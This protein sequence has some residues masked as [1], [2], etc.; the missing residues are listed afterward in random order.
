MIGECA[1]VCTHA[2]AYVLHVLGKNKAG[3][4]VENVEG[5]RG[6][7]RGHGAF[8]WGLS[9]LPTFRF[10]FR[11]AGRAERAAQPGCKSCWSWLDVAMETRSE[12]GRLNDQA[13]L[14][15]LSLSTKPSVSRTQTVS[16][17]HRGC[18]IH[19]TARGPQPY[20][21]SLCTSVHGLS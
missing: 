21:L 9:V 15:G 4:R 8:P 13:V 3:S 11:R 6:R 16:T 20:C 7:S 2:R 10:P 5:P 14:P 18:N 17:N 19:C 12:T 1:C